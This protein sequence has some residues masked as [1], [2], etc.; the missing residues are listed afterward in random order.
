LENDPS[1][2]IMHGVLTGRAREGPPQQ[3]NVH[4]PHYSISSRLFWTAGPTSGNWHGLR[5]CSIFGWQQAQAARCGVRGRSICMHGQGT[6]CTV[7]R[8]LS[9]LHKTIDV[10]ALLC[11]ATAYA[12]FFF[13][14]KTCPLPAVYKTS[15]TTT[16]II[17]LTKILEPLFGGL[18]CSFVSLLLVSNL[19][20][21]RGISLA[22]CF[23][24]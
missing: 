5:R 9:S 2:E 16:Y 24:N 1:I 3:L 12:R 8:P 13:W 17:F 20:W 22:R 18:I 7:L 21:T 23:G 15:T 10:A 14:T 6:L 11:R 4:A 19:L